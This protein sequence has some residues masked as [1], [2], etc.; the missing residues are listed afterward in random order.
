MIKAEQK[1]RNMPNFEK[2]K[3]RGLRPQISPTIETDLALFVDKMYSVDETKY[4]GFKFG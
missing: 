1:K 2:Q 4:V 3:F